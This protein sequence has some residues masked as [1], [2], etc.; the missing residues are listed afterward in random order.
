MTDWELADWASHLA[1]GRSPR[2]WGRVILLNEPRILLIWGLRD[3]NTGDNSQLCSCLFLPLEQE[4]GHDNWQLWMSETQNVLINQGI[5]QSLSGNSCGQD[6]EMQTRWQYNL[7]DSELAKNLFS[8]S[9][10]GRGKEG[11][12]GGGQQWRGWGGL[13]QKVLSLG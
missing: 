2:V 1:Y 10:E 3:S 8:K 11:S 12:G 5:W 13:C 9:A 4:A 6:G 7:G